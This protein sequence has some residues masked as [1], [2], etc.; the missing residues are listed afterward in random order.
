MRRW[1]IVAAVV[2]IMSSLLVID[3]RAEE[4]ASQDPLCGANDLPEGEA[5]N[6]KPTPQLQGDVPKAH[7]DGENADGLTRA[8]AGYNCGLELVAREVL[9]ADGRKPTGNANMAWASHCA[10]VSGA[11]TVFGP[12]E[13]DPATDDP[14]GLAVIDVHDPADPKHVRTLKNE[15]TTQVLETIYAIDARD[16]PG[17]PITHSILVVGVYGNNTGPGELSGNDLMHVYDVTGNKC[18]HPKRVG[19]FTFPENIH[20]LTISGNG[21]YVF[22]TSPNQVLSIEGLFDHDPRTGMRFLGNLDEVTD[23]PLV[24]ISP[25]ADLDDLAPPARKTPADYTAHQVWSN[26][27][28]NLLYMGGTVKPF[29]VFTIL[30]ITDWLRDGTKPTVVSQRNGRGHSVTKTSIAGQ[31][32]WVMHAEES[33]F[34]L[35]YGCFGEEGAPF[36]G[37][38]EPSFS[39]VTDPANPTMHVSKFSLDINKQEN[40]VAQMASGVQ[41]STHYHEFD[42]SENAKIAIVSMQNAGI[43]VVDV[44]DPTKPREIAYFNPGDVDDGPGVTLDNAWGHPKFDAK[45]G[46]IWFATSSG[47]FWV[48]RL[49]KQVLEALGMSVLD[50]ASETGAPGTLLA[51]SSNVAFPAAEPPPVW[52]TLSVPLSKL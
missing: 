30:D 44:R 35:A 14:N 42:S 23:Y 31:G 5:L 51:G 16:T 13:Y 6:G 47:G 8:E 34:D 36:A 22:A 38:A 1:G 26:F 2:A 33:V 49:E 25:V 7:Q 9:D 15:A 27:D 19:E 12:A 24:G 20:N 28:G 50:G 17:G 41:A 52:C 40:C 48:V 11:G 46:T 3:A 4:S 18:E 39:N 43:R 29:E 10:Y 37:V 32:E 45:S 21:R